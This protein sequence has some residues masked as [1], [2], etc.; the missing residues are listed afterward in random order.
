MTVQKHLPSRHL[1]FQFQHFYFSLPPS[2]LFYFYDFAALGLD[3]G[4]DLFLQGLRNDVVMRHFHVEAAPALGHGG[5]VSAVGQHFRHGHLGFDDGLAALV[6]HSLNASAAP[7]KVAHNGAGKLVGHGDFHRHN[8][9]QQRG[10]GLLHGLFEGNAARHLEG[11][12]VGI[13]VVVGAVVE[14]HSEI[15]HR[16]AGQEAALRR[17]HNAL[18][19]CGNEVT[20]DGA[21]ENVV[22]EL[23]VAAARQRLHLDL[24]VAVLAVPPGLLLVPAL[25]VGF[26]ADGFAVGHLGRLQI[27]LGVVALF[28]FGND[29]FDVLLAG[30]GDEEFLG[31][32]VTEEAQHGVLFHDL[33]D[34]VGE[35]VFIGARL[36]FDGEGDGRL[37]QDDLGVL[38]SRGL[39]AQGVAGKSVL[40]LGHRS[41][42]AGVQ[43][44]HRHRVFALHHGNVGQLFRGAAAKVLQ[45]G[46]VFQHPG[47]DLVIRNAAGE[48]VGNGFENQKRDRFGVGNF[49]RRRLAVVGSR[50]A[51]SR[52]ALAGGR[53]VVHQEIH[54]LVG[55]DV[56]QAGGEEHRE[57]AVFA[58]GLVQGRD[59]VL[60]GDGSLVEELFHQG[61]IALGDHF[62]QLFVGFLSGAGQVRGNFAFLALAVATHVVGVGLHADEVDD[63][64]Q[65]LFASD[66]HLQG[67]DGAA[68]GGGQ[69]FQHA[70]G[71]GAF[72]VHAGGDDY[73]REVELVGVVPDA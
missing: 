41:D 17:L 44:V 55:A 66:G 49:A 15:H 72:A 31:L 32:L 61:V 20:G 73:A 53:R 30:A 38:N 8:R 40:Q 36:G 43:F 48:G 63:P 64:A 58:D 12:F 52:L 16:V 56:A 1:L 11:K 67:H 37:G 45:A 51:L 24:A 50:S 22:N 33:V 6:V 14:D 71:V 39:V 29:D 5:Q 65:A 10:L 4:D 13:H 9:L 19:Y 21:A 57:D 26:A 27:D 69:R 2:L 7:V 25:H 70:G 35:L 3:L 34:A 23:K 62:H 54:Q 59:E 18:L 46:V 42:I 68:E 28:Q 47:E 60:F